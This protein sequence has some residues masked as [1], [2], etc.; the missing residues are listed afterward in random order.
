M[1]TAVRTRSQ[2]SLLRLFLRI[3][4]S[5]HNLSLLRFRSTKRD[6][7]GSVRADAETTTIPTFLIFKMREKS[8]GFCGA[9]VKGRMNT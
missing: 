3:F 4:C 9:K 5:S 7:H 2:V 8:K 6:I 1:Y